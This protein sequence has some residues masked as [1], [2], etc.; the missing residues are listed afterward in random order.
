MNG[1]IVPVEKSLICEIVWTTFQKYYFTR[2][3]I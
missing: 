1:N 3:Q 2:E